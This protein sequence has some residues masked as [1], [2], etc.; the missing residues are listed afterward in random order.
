MSYPSV[1]ALHYFAKP[2][3]VKCDSSTG[4]RSYDDS[5]EMEALSIGPNIQ[6][7]DWQKKKF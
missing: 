4:N 2:F 1:L 3:V 6:N 7:Q 5:V